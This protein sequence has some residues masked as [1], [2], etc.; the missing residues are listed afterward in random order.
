M[1]KIGLIKELEKYPVFNLKIVRDIIKKDN[2]YTKLVIY[3]LKKEKL[4]LEI[5]KNK[6]TVNKDSFLIASNII[7]PSYI[8]CWSAL[9][10]Y[11][12]TEQLPTI[13]QIIT[14]KKRKKT[15]INFNNAKIVFIKTKSK[16]FFGYKK[17]RYKNFDIFIAEK[18]KALIDSV[19]FKKISLLEIYDII[20]NN[21]NDIN[22]NL[23]VDYLIKTKNKTLIKRFGFLF[24]KLSVNK[25][26][27]FKKYIDFKY[28]PFDYSIRKMGIKNKKWRI[29]E[30][31]K[32]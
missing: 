29:I 23:F 16:N 20:K 18:E 13:I 25:Y 3:R 32:L 1:K 8:S 7:W 5:E 10:Y 15:E 6:Y 12:L 9:R 21:I 11:N 28:I 19:L 2:Y 30:N 26:D 4:I 27:K 31:V 17:E 24:D 22:I 14:T